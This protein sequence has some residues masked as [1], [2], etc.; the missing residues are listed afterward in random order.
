MDRIALL[1]D[2]LAAPKRFL[3]VPSDIAFANI[4]EVGYITSL[5]SDSVLRVD[6]AMDPPVAGSPG[7]ASFLGTGRS[8]TGVAID[9]ARHGE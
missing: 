5:V 8:P 1:I 7:G 4:G 3:P 2:D 9:D 6:F